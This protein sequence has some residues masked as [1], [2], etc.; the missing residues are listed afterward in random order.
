M[1]NIENSYSSEQKMNHQPPYTKVLAV[2]LSSVDWTSASA[3]MFVGE[4][5]NKVAGNIKVDTID[6]TGIIY[7]ADAYDIV[8]ARITKIYKSGT[9]ATNI[10][11]WGYPLAQ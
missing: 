9:T 3:S 7:P 1:N 2:D 11:V 10:T 6:S 5:R 4:M 8:R